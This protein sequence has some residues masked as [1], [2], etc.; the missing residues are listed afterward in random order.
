MNGTTSPE[1]IAGTLDSLV[2]YVRRFMA[3]PP[4]QVHAVVLWAAHTHVFQ[5]FET[6]PFLAVTSPQKRCGKSRLLDVLE[7]VV[8]CPW[9]TVMPSE[10][11]LFR[12]IN[13]QRPTLMLDETDAI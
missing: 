1:A 8:A 2:L 9:R 13:A 3:M 5:A 4:A 6:T 10:A 11:V 7:L 12:K